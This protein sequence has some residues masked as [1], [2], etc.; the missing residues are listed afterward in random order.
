MR[1]AGVESSWEQFYQLIHVQFP[2]SRV[3]DIQIRKGIVLSF[4][5]VQHTHLLTREAAGATR[6]AP[7]IW[8]EQWRRL[9]E[10]CQEA[11]DV[12]LPEIHFRDGSP[13][14]IQAESPGWRFEGAAVA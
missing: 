1:R 9:V 2:H 11:Q 3:A 6:S 13:Q 14:T 4:K 7:E 8:N 12:D 10:F 5:R